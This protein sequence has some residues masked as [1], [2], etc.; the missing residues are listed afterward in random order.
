MSPLTA[1][2]PSRVAVLCAALA[3]AAAPATARC[4]FGRLRDAARAATRGAVE[5]GAEQRAGDAAA[6]QAKGGDGAEARPATVAF[7]P[8][9]LEI[10]DARLAQLLR[11]LDAE[12]AARPAAERRQAALVAAAREA[13]RTYPARRAAYERERAAWERR[14]AERTACVDKVQARHAGEANAQ[15]AQGEAVARDVEARMAGGRA[16]DLEG[17][18]AR[19]RAAQARGDQAALM[20][21]ADSAQRIMRNEF[22]PAVNAGM[23]MAQR[24]AADS[25]AINAEAA[26]C[27][28]R[29]PEPT[30]PAP[31]PGVDPDGAAA[32]V[33]R[34]GQAA[35]GL[36][37]RQYAVLRER[38]EEFVRL[39]GRTGATRYRF[40]AG[41]LAA[42]RGRMAA[43]KGNAAL[44]QGGSWTPLGAAGA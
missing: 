19:A 9:V 35:S 20:A 3:I 38:V 43:L 27:G 14:E 5:R 36:D 11:G 17:L 23:A 12:A 34:A 40:T 26:A 32:A 44:Q 22:A 8:D 31:V 2:A 41:E 25:K 21:L 7:T 29:T 4:Q 30:S 42:L 16:A 24:A 18:A 39:D 28:A 15:R 13:E 1:L 37:E 10:T 6:R 33:H